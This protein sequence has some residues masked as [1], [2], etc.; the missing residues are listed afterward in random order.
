MRYTYL[1][2][3]MTDPALIGAACDPVFRD[4]GK[5]IVSQRMA[6]QLVRFAG[7]DFNRVVK[8]RRLRVNRPALDTGANPLPTT[9]EGQEQ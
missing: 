7:E 3:A 4:D 1:G 9:T 2:D 8:R 5:C 6:T